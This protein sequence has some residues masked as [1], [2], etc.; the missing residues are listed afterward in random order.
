MA[1]QKLL[2]IYITSK[3]SAEAR[4]VAAHL[5]KKRL[6]A[7]ANIFPISSMYRWKGKIES[8]REAVLIGKTLPKHYLAIKKEVRRI[9]SYSTPCIMKIDAEANR[10]FS[11]WLCGEVKQ[12]PQRI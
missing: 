3:D 7:C 1:K 12:G 8:G 10:E 9:H 6:I 4:K 5:M 11:G 2:L